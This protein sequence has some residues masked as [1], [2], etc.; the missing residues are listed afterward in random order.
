MTPEADL[1]AFL[2]QREQTQVVEVDQPQVQLVVFT[3][4][5][6][7]F[8]LRGGQVKEVLSAQQAVF[9]LPGQDQ[10]VEGVLTLRG[11][12]YPVWQAESLL[13]LS[14]TS[15]PGEGAFQAAL[16]LCQAR[17][18]EQQQAVVLRVGSLMDV[19]DL[20]EDRLQPPSSSLISTLGAQAEAVFEWQG[21]GVTLLDL[22][23]L[24][25]DWWQRRAG[26]QTA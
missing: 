26:A 14:V 25:Q 8:A 16:L 3:L 9:A 2:A 1:A 19:I 18:D 12:L 7:V 24:M 5:G 4:G 23:A 13:G 17:V 15:S 20:S 21:Q 10:S 22:H 11:Q 6:D